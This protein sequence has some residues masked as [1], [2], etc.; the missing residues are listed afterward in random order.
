MPGFRNALLTA[1]LLMISTAGSF[2]EDADPDV[3]LKDSFEK[4]NKAPEGWKA[5]AEIPGVKYVY[6][7]KT[8]SEGERS[9]ALDKAANRYFPIA[10]WHRTLERKGSKPAINVSVKVKAS[11]ATKAIVDL[12]FLDAQGE[13]INHEW[14]AY[15][16]Q[17]E[18]A[19]PVATHDW[20]V[21]EGT[22]DVPQGTRQIAVALQV[23]GPGK[24]WFDELEVRQVDPNAPATDGQ[25]PK[26]SQLA[27]PVEESVDTP[28]PIE[29]PSNTGSTVRY[30]LIPPIDGTVKPASGYRL[31]LVLPGGDGSA[32]F[33][34]FVRRIHEQALEGEFVVAQL[35]APDHVVW[36][37]KASTAYSC[38]TEEAI[39]TIIADVAARQTIDPANIYALA[40]SS[41]GPAVYAA[42]LQE[43]SP[44]AGAFI[45][46][47]VFKPQ[48]LPPL[49]Y[50]KNRRAYL[51]HSREDSTCPYWMAEL[52][53]EE[54][55]SAGAKVVLVDYAG[56]HGW[57]GPVF[58]QIRAGMNWLQDSST[59]Q[60]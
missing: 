42:L 1:A 17:K 22:A 10:Q 37:T 36:P 3:L 23:Y 51:L 41:S 21:Y 7:R 18:Q 9:L 58:E 44:L 28:A 20:K 50:S 29:V 6:D 60:R 13:Q 54:F 15:I 14:V 43:D 40:W 12:Q 35:L 38:T 34:P 33:H 16:G 48:Q 4:G 56:G 49:Q 59:R 27:E 57:H 24:V 25:T 26:T 5:G 53:R 8:A 52:A 32:E 31:L 2:A 55:E 39:G 45:A 47:S 19:D 46:M 30:L 11:K